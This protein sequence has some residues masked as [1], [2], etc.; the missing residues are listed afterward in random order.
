MKVKDL[1]KLGLEDFDILLVEDLL[2]QK[3]D[4]PAHCTFSLEMVDTCY[5]EK[6]ITLGKVK[7]VSG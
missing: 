4:W 1:V 7:K 6:I 2:L 5:S 3:G